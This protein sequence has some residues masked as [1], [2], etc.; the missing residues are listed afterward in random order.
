MSDTP[1]KW[2]LG[3]ILLVNKPLHWTSFDV[4]NKLKFVLLKTY[5][6]KIKIGHAGTLDPLASGLLVI[7]TGKKTKEISDIQDG[8]KEYTT[9]LKLGATTPSFDVETEED[10]QYPTEHITKTLVYQALDK[11]I[12]KQDQIPPIYSAVKTNG[13][14][15]YEYARNGEEL[16]LQ[17]KQITIY[18]LEIKNIDLPFLTLRVVCGKGTYIRSLARDIGTT[19]QSGAYLTSLVRTR[20]GAFGL[21]DAK[22][23]EEMAE[24]IMNN[25]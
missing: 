25:E 1:N 13:K 18:E 19:L 20:I 8:L 3:Q 15:A 4:V 14:R 6:E 17:P 24:I 2:Q 12:G 11:F 7:C 9:T 10:N 21:E 5:N 23:V 22:T 16:V